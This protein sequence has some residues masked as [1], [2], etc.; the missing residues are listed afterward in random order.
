VGAALV[1][2]QQAIV[3]DWITPPEHDVVDLLRKL[4]RACV[5]DISEP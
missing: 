2:A 1:A 3:T 5:T 4:G